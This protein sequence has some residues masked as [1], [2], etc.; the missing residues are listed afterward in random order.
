MILKFLSFIYFHVKTTD[1]KIAANIFLKRDHKKLEAL[2][3]EYRHNKLGVYM[4]P[5]MFYGGVPEAVRLSE[6]NVQNH[7]DG[8]RGDIAERAM[9]YALKKYFTSTG[10]DVSI[11]HSHKFL[12]KKSTSEKDFIVFN[13]SK[14]KLLF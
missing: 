4:I 9:Y 3:F 5:P 14:G 8:V 11:I 10:D 12:N 13:L 2:P 7:R 6:F 1:P